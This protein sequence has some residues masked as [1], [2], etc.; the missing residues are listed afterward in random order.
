MENYIYLIS[1][2]L[3]AMSIALLIN[4]QYL[5]AVIKENEEELASLRNEADL[6]KASYS[7][8]LMTE[9]EIRTSLSNELKNNKAYITDIE[10]KQLETNKHLFKLQESS[11]LLYQLLMAIFKIHTSFKKEYDFRYQH[12]LSTISLPI[13]LSGDQQNSMIAIIDS[14]MNFKSKSSKE[15]EK[16]KAYLFDAMHEIITSTTLEKKSYL[17]GTLNNQSFINFPDYNDTVY[18]A[19]ISLIN[20][21][22]SHD[23]AVSS[24]ILMGNELLLRK[25]AEEVEFKKELLRL[26]AEEIKAR[27]ATMNSLRSS[28]KQDTGAE[29]LLELIQDDSK[30][31]VTE[32]RE[33]KLGNWVD[34]VEQ[35]LEEDDKEKEKEENEKP[36]S[37]LEKAFEKYG[38]VFTDEFKEKHMDGYVIPLH[39]EEQPH[40]ETFVI[41]PDY[42]DSPSDTTLSSDNPSDSSIGGDDF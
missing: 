38:E 15:R 41:I 40:K 35:M 36:K 25:V 39:N 8:S 20:K 12:I 21:E 37:D 2:A 14:A 1:V 19:I 23:P 42:P 7:K 28:I 18:S 24:A 26:E 22:F 31:K 16:H 10:K 33:E 29:G 3:L 30:G 13:V 4:K 9:L 17:L 34:K 6:V 11:D 32:T 5:K 27:N